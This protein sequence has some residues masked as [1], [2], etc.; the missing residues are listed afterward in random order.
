MNDILLQP[1]S[2]AFRASLSGNLSKINHQ[3]GCIFVRAGQDDAAVK[4][5][6]PS[7]FSADPDYAAYYVD[8]VFGGL[9]GRDCRVVA[10][11]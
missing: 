10:H 3:N 2:I 8:F 9:D 5:H 6:G 11:E 7:H 1:P 4:C